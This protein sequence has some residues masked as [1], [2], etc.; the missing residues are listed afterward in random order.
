MKKYYQM[1]IDLGHIDSMY[2][3]GMYYQMAVDLGDTNYVYYLDLYYKA[4]EQKL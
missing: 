4:V 1:A 3:L 2:N